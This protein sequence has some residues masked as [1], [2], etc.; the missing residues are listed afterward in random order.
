M[1]G[2]ISSDNHFDPEWNAF[3][4]NRN[5]WC[6]YIQQPIGTNVA[7][8]PK[9][10]CSD[11]VQYL[12]FE[13]N[14]PGKDHIKGRDAIGCDHHQPLPGNGINISYLTLIKCSLIR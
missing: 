4:S 13:R 8:S 1:T 6:R 5:I 3:F 11:L 10:I 2:K 7:G 12:S 14:W 9:H